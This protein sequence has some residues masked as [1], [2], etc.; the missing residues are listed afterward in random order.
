MAQFF[1]FQRFIS[2]VSGKAINCNAPNAKFVANQ[3]NYQRET[4]R[5]LWRRSNADLVE[6]PSAI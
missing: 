5:L 4:L 2:S 3:K 6:Q 1:C